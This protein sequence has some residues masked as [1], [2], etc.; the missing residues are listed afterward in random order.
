MNLA[1]RP[2]I[3]EACCGFMWHVLA[4]TE[5]KDVTAAVW[6]M[7]PGML[8][9]SSVCFMHSVPTTLCSGVCVGLGIACLAGQQEVGRG[10]DQ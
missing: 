8:R 10:V 2:K 4:L 9:T 5:G 7:Q 1:E 3:G 6:C